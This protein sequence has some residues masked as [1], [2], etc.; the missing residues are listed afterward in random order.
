M[1]MAK[2]DPQRSVVLALHFQNDIAHENGKMGFGTGA[3]RANVVEAARRLIEGARAASAPVVH[4]RVAFR[5][6]Y[7]E[8]LPNCILF[9]TVAEKG[10]LVDGTWG[11]EFFEGLQPRPDE[12]VVTHR[13]VNPFYGSA[14]EEIV[15]KLEAETVIVSGVAT[16]YVVDHA[17]RHACDVGY[18]AVVAADA[19]STRTP[20]AHE[21]TLQTLALLATISTVTEI[22]AAWKR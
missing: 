19:C 10:A 14:L 15:R 6:D 8:V 16:N 17:V 18:E 13:R 21:A 4:V 9:K 12:F 2:M 11:A 5:A 1:T 3:K 20:E 22:L 7:K